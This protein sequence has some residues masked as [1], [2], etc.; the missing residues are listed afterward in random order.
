MDVRSALP[1]SHL[2]DQSAFVCAQASSQSATSILIDTDQRFIRLCGYFSARREQCYLF[3]FFFLLFVLQACV[4]IEASRDA[5]ADENEGVRLPGRVQLAFYRKVF[6][7]SCRVW[8]STFAKQRCIEKADFRRRGNKV[9]NI[10]RGLSLVRLKAAP[11][12]RHVH[13]PVLIGRQNLGAANFDKFPLVFVSFFTCKCNNV[14]R[15]EFFSYIGII[16]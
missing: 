5:L 4:I 16:D 13:K 8:Y 11:Y 6:D 1:P 2:D 7:C 10:I 15:L 12:S 9:S 14:L 3:L